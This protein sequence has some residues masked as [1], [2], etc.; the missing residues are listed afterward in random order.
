MF[1]LF[2]SR[3]DEGVAKFIIEL[4][5]P[6]K[7]PSAT[8]S[9]PYCLGFLEIV[10]VHVADLNKKGTSFADAASIFRKALD[11]ITPLY[12]DDANLALAIA[13]TETSPNHEAYLRGRK[14]GDAFMAAR[15]HHI[16]SDEKGQ[17]LLNRF[18]ERARGVSTDIATV[19]LEDK[20]KKSQ[21]LPTGG[22]RLEKDAVIRDYEFP[23][24]PTSD[25]TTTL[26]VTCW[27]TRYANGKLATTIDFVL[28]PY[29]YLMPDGQS[30]PD[31][32]VTPPFT[33]CLFAAGSGAGTEDDPIMRGGFYT[34]IACSRESEPDE[35]FLRLDV[36]REN[37]SAVNVIA[38]GE[39]LTFSIHQPKADPPIRLKLELANDRQFV[40]LYRQ[41][42]SNV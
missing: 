28:K 20:P 32:L 23:G 25:T 3:Q 40:N 14:D 2:K 22:W 31:H 1:G 19:L 18:I 39:K 7:L 26:K 10:G 9:D 12:A 4:L 30:F 38:T 17:D 33:V 36:W 6:L 35:V 8:F 11:K 41:I 13:K 42:C 27:V 16:L 24:A 21:V 15:L 34:V 29:L 37:A 5:A